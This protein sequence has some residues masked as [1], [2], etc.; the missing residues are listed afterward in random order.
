MSK[1]ADYELGKI[2][3]KSGTHSYIYGA[4]HLET[5][6]QIAI[7]RIQ[8]FDLHAAVRK[9]VDTEISLL[10]KLD[11]PNLIQYHEHFHHE[12]DLY[13]VM[14]LATGG[15]MAQKVEAVRKTSVF[16]EESLIWRW[17]SDVASGLAYL[18]SRR[19]LHRDVKPSHIFVSENGQAK[20]GDFGLSK[21][22]SAKT[23]AAFSCVGTPFYMSPELVKSEGY[24]FGSDVWSLACSIYEL[25]TGYP[26][27]FRADMDFYALGDA[28]CS[29]R[30]PALP[31]ETWSRELSALI[32]EILTVDPRQ[33]PTAQKILDATTC[34]RAGGMQEF[35]VF[36][37]IGRGKFSEVHRARRKGATESQVALK[38]VQIFEMDSEA[39]KDCITEVN[40]LKSLSHLTIVRY[41]DSFTD[42]NEL[43]IVLELAPHGDLAGLCRS[44]KESERSLTE[45]ETWATI[46]QISDALYYMH[47]K[48]IMH[49]DIK[50]ANVFLCS[51]GV[52]KLGD[53]GL[54]RYFSSN[55]YRAHSV[56]GTPFYM[57]PEVITYSGG[58]S[59]GYS[60]KSDIWSLG[61]VLYE[62]AALQSPF[63]CSRLNYYALGKQICSGD[64]PALPDASSRNVQKLCSEMIQVNPEHRPSAHAVFVATDE[65]FS[66]IAPALPPPPAANDSAPPRAEATSETGQKVH[67]VHMLLMRAAAVV[68]NRIEAIGLAVPSEEQP[69]ASKLPWSAGTSA[70]PSQQTSV[71]T[72]CGSAVA[73]A[74]SSSSPD[75]SSRAGVASSRRAADRPLPPA[76]AE[77]STPSAPSAPSA[78]PPQSAREPRLSE[79][80]RPV[81]SAPVPKRPDRAPPYINYTVPTPPGVPPP[82]PLRENREDGTSSSGGQ[83]HVVRR[84]PVPA[85]GSLSARGSSRDRQPLDALSHRRRAHTPERGR[86]QPTNEVSHLRFAGSGI[87]EVWKAQ[88]EAKNSKPTAPSH[89]AHESKPIN[90]RDLPPI[91][92]RTPREASR[93]VSAAGRA[94]GPP[95]RDLTGAP[96]PMPPSRAPISAP[97]GGGG[98]SEDLSSPPSARRPAHPPAAV[99][100]H[101]AAAVAGQAL[102]ARGRA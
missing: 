11:H 51:Q 44:L 86:Q 38:R 21:A 97:G 49:R 52:V 95:Q 77:V 53:L 4:T 55:T 76:V 26:P 10:Q 84:R 65:H 18:H 24:A 60:F 89:Q 36:G 25:A 33:R 12:N 48:R 2:I 8:L 99:P 5:G 88:P 69:S 9:E 40:L 63:A 45:T 19:V 37:N 81:A 83:S 3:S 100:L 16:V 96:P 90:M 64:Y 1:L 43:V 87:S 46:F 27:F 92:P 56:V 54:G 31:P 62:L 20:L 67:R 23:Q 82:Q 6:T 42:N 68:R 7:K 29:A 74:R 75:A 102:Q 61:C 94:D 93:E 39:R 14:E 50:P 30:Y 66:S 91:K 13:I 80:E 70:Y 28:I 34:N 73:Y 72:V 78:P 17:L 101:A 47:K 15:Q 71:N 79:R 58:P 22:M 32:A 41:L 85:G 59:G 98:G 35:Q 57:S